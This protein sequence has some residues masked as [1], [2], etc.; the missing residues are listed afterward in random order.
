ML[1]SQNQIVRFH[2]GYQVKK[3]LIVLLFLTFY[4]TGSAQNNRAALI[5]KYAGKIDS[6][7]SLRKRII[8]DTITGAGAVWQNVNIELYYNASGQVVKL[9]DKHVYNK[10]PNSIIFYYKDKKA[11]KATIF[12]F[13]RRTI[14]SPDYYFDSVV[15]FKN[16]KVLKQ[17]DHKTP[18]NAKWFL[19]SYNELIK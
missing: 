14:D 4:M 8:K 13:Q 6:D 3:F 2:F 10:H 1:I 19:L 15:Y 18:V 9:Q 11:V 12:A 5:D 17:I 7:S 16:G